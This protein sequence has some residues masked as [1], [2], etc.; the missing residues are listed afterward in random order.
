MKNTARRLEIYDAR[1]WGKVFL[2]TALL[3]LAAVAVW[4]VAVAHSLR[5]GMTQLGLCF[6]VVQLGLSLLLLFPAAGRLG[7][8]IMLVSV[9]HGGFVALRA[10]TQPAE[11]L[12]PA[13]PG[14]HKL[15]L[16]LGV[17]RGE[18]GHLDPK[19]FVGAEAYDVVSRIYT[20]RE[21]HT[22]SVLFAL[23][24][25]PGAGVYH[26]PMNCYQSN[27]W[28]NRDQMRLPLQTPNRPEIPVSLSTWESKEDRVVVLY[29][30][31]MGEHTLFDR[32]DWGTVRIQLRGQKTWPPMYKV[33]LQTSAKDS[34]DR[35][36]LLDVAGSIR[37]WLGELGASDQAAG[38]AP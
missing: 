2:V 34:K 27:G 33:L 21:G 20:D 25:D 37:K 17:W 1:L 10:G 24:V 13:P 15:P 31:E 35:A 22:V 3:T 28:T 4:G 29:W 14:I 6:A 7:I 16:T 36:R 19:L 11:V 8:L 18:E 32:W 38:G 12:I 5:G 26:T 9:V 23:Y 30:Y